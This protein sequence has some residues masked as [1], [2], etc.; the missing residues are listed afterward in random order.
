MVIFGYRSINKFV[1]G[2]LHR[3]QNC[4]K[5]GCTQE[6]HEALHTPY[7][8]LYFIPLFP[9]DKGV[10][11]LACRRCDTAYTMQ[12]NNQYAHK[13]SQESKGPADWNAP[14]IEKMVITCIHCHKE[15][16]VPN[17]ER[18]LLIT[19]PHC[20]KKFSRMMI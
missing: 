14:P 5:C 9:L 19:C 6:L 4:P 7:F 2:G 20:G 1:S 12:P 11:V 18:T 17:D 15:S 3:Q 8:T 13:P 10:R 16:R